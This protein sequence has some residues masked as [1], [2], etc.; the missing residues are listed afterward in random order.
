MFKRIFGAEARKPLLV[1]LLNHLLELERERRILEVQHLRG[2]QR[3]DVLRL[4]VSR[5]FEL[6]EDARAR[7]TACADIATLDRWF[8]RAL[9]A[10]TV[11][12]VV[13]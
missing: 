7:I 3:V 2:D 8:D 11:A 4:L 1:A 6:T 10:K 5:G 9:V 13:S 12:D